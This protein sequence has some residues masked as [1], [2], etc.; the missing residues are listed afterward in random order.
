MFIKDHKMINNKGVFPTRFF[1]TA[2]NLTA[3]FLKLEYI[4]INRALDKANINYSRIIVF[5]ST[6]LK[7]DLEYIGL[8]RDK[9]TIVSVDMVNMYPSIKNSLIS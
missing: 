8:N 4:G 1:I 3:Y 2:K 9:V 6:D 7:Q 5:Q